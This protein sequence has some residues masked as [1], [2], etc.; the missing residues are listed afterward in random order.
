MS[1]V[2]QTFVW[3]LKCV[4]VLATLWL[5]LVGCCRMSSTCQT[6]SATIASLQQQWPSSTY[7]ASLAFLPSVLMGY[8]R[9]LVFW[10]G[11]Q[12]CCGAPCG[13]CGLLCTWVYVLELGSRSL[14][15]PVVFFPDLLLDCVLLAR[16][17]FTSH[18]LVVGTSIFVAR[19]CKRSTRSS[20]TTATRIRVW[21]S[22]FTLSLLR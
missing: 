9:R 21:S 5:P 3:A 20:L 2:V 4:F 17:T 6:Q 10:T 18:P 8:R 13:T 16:H 12:T 15:R 14:P 7:P 11:R 22:R 1:P 19:V